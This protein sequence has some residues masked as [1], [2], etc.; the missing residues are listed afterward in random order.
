MNIVEHTLF[1]DLVIKVFNLNITC[2]VLIL[3]LNPNY[4]VFK[5]LE[6]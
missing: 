2:V 3:L 6:S 1:I 5:I 4:K